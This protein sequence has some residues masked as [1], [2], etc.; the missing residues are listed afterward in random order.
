MLN[1]RLLSLSHGTRVAGF[2][3]GM[4]RVVVPSVRGQ[5]TTIHNSMANAPSMMTT[6]VAPIGELTAWRAVTLGRFAALPSFLKVAVPIAARGMLDA[7][8]SKRCGEVV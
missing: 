7:S 2:T 1:G 8:V 5:A 3:Q 6:S 4:R